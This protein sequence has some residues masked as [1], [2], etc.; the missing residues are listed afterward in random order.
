VQPTAFA[1]V[2]PGRAVDRVVFAG[3]ADRRQELGD[4]KTVG[5]LLDVLAVGPPAEVVGQLDFLVRAIQQRN[6][7][8]EKIPGGRVGDVL[9]VQF[10]IGLI[11]RVHV[12]LEVVG[13]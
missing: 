3:P 8:L 5:R 10:V 11:K 4:H 2:V 7:V 12:V 1:D 6:V 13:L 9:P